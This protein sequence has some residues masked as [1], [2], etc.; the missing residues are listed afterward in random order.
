VF[1]ELISDLPKFSETTRLNL[2]W[3]A[4]KFQYTISLST[5]KPNNI[6]NWKFYRKANDDSVLLWQHE[7]NDMLLLYNLIVQETS[8]LNTGIN[9]DG[10]ICNATDEMRKSDL[11][12]TSNIS[13][14]L[15]HFLT[16]ADSPPA[17]ETDSFSNMPSPFQNQQANLNDAS[18]SQPIIGSIDLQIGRMFLQ[19]TLINDLN[20]HS[21]S[22]FLF[23]LEQELFRSL[24]AKNYPITLIIIQPYQI[25]TAGQAVTCSKDEAY[26]IAN[27]VKQLKRKT[28]ILAQYESNRL[29]LLLPE[30]DAIGGEKVATKTQKAFQ[31][32]LSHSQL[33]NNLNKTKL[34]FGVAT[35]S[36]QTNTLSRFLSVTEQSC[37]RAIRSPNGIYVHEDVAPLK[38]IEPKIIDVYPVRQLI[39][40]LVSM[41]DGIFLFP[42][43]VSLLEREFHLAKRNQID[44]YMMHLRIPE[45]LTD[46][47]HQNAIAL[48]LKSL[49]PG[50]RCGHY[51]FKDNEYAIIRPKATINDLL[52]LLKQ[53]RTALDSVVPVEGRLCLIQQNSQSA[54][55]LNLI[56]AM[57]AQA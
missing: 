51:D 52:Q 11:Y 38:K 23:C 55:H 33:N 57:P 49:G 29:A 26:Q 7:T 22:A 40:Q 50:D 45:T 2:T 56:D 3:P 15:R 41:K 42:M 48:L 10:A 1:Q 36:N 44:S 54:T 53:I 14:N 12:V 19:Q 8:A 5:R 46:E 32:L 27:Q 39:L 25:N 47:K 34:V 20:I 13:D 21:F 6:G 28:D 4:G 24:A 9:V 35:L 43:F 37:V 17:R 16:K 30:T 18:K 31:E